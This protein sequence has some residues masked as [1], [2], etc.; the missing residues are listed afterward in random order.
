MHIICEDLTKIYRQGNDED[1]VAVNTCR[2][3]IPPGRIVVLLGVSGSG[4][5]TLL[6]MLGLLEQPTSGRILFDSVDVSTLSESERSKMRTRDIGF[7]HQNYNLIP[8][9]S[10]EEN[11]ALSRYI[12]GKSYDKA[13]LTRLTDLLQ[14]SSKLHAFPAALSGGQQQ[15]VAIARALINR[16]GLILADEPTGNLDYQT[17]QEIMQ[18]F[19]QIHIEFQATVVIVTHDHSFTEIAD[20][21]YVMENGRPVPIP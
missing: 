15:R 21:V 19:L 5:T 6:K 17:K 12:S 4:K 9:L 18:L 1:V 3:D 8:L 13:E 7:V 2:L 20:Q 14:I 16:P 10:V 11:I